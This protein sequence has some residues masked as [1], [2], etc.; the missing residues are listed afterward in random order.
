MFTD[1]ISSKTFFFLLQETEAV[2]ED[3]GLEGWYFS[4]FTVWYNDG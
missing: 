4:N 3:D 1:V 2:E